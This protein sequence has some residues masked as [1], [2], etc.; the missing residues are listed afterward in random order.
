MSRSGS[1]GGVF[2]GPSLAGT[3]TG[4]PLN[5]Y[6]R[7]QYAHILLVALW[8]A[9]YALPNL[10]PPDYAVQVSPASPDVPLD[11]RILGRAQAVLNTANVDHFGDAIVGRAAVL[12]VGN[13]T[14]QLK[15]Q[16]VL[17][18]A[19]RGAD[20]TDSYVVALNMAASTPAWLE[21]V[22][23]RPMKYGLD[24]S[25]GVHFLLE[26]DM[27]SAMQALLTSNSGQMRQM[28][29]EK[30]IR[31]L[32]RP[33]IANGLEFGFANVAARVQ[34]REL[35]T[36][37]FSDFVMQD[38]ASPDGPLLRMVLSKSAIE[39]RQTY[40]IEQNLQSLRKRVNE[41]G[42]SEPLVQRLGRDRIAVDLPG[43]QDS[44]YAKQILGKIA[45]LEF[46]LL[47]GPDTGPSD[48][49]T[50]EYRLEQTV[51]QRSN[52]VTGNNVTDARPSQDPQTNEPEVSITLD[53]DGGRHMY[54]ATK[55]N[56]GRGMAILYIEKQTRTVTRMVDGK[57]VEELQRY[58]VK[59]LISV[60]TIQAALSSQFRIT[61][62]AIGEAR[63]LSLLLRSGALAAPMYI[64][65][66]RTVGASLGEQNVRQGLNAGLIGILLV[67]GCMV[68]NYRLLGLLSCVALVVNVLL[69]IAIM[70]LVGVTLTLPG[71]AGI[72]LTIGMAV[73][74]NVLIFCRIQEE[75]QE[76]T[77][78]AAIHAGFDRAFTTIADSNLTTFIVAA[79]L[80]LIGS[81]PIKGF[82]VVL[83][84]GLATSVFTAVYVT[85][86]LVNLTYGGRNIEKVSV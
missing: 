85:R 70:S 65:E 17:A 79:I 74:A 49:E 83:S 21:T 71:I 26:V 60:A 7:W 68:L 62:L 42:V 45:N 35:L 1:D 56:I 61:G 22:G 24:L 59:R 64:V 63:E 12:R 8:A 9:V 3:G 46:R 19:L 25:G 33:A 44:A 84:I 28:M 34:A 81:G 66:E 86:A 27:Q 58:D 2:G 14:E 31:Y 13:A 82:A 15:A 72:A 51:L 53:S 43:L 47:S 57:A 32:S 40:S 36:R 48:T 67:A 52:I 29:R 11:P 76:R 5:T 4:R 16:R 23:G 41:L 30:R 78:Q 6:A 39:S 50:Y 69:L 37:Q 38:V 77:P 55:G 73:D 80:F 54:D 18:Q 10:F 20:G 75:L